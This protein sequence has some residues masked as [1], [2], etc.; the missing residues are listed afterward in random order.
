MATT[1]IPGK[2]VS[3]PK[4]AKYNEVVEDRK[5]LSDSKQALQRAANI[6]F[7]ENSFLSGKIIFRTCFKN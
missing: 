1:S 3:Q 5:T 4:L 6:E 7:A 2:R